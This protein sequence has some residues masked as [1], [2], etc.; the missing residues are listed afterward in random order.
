MLI[1]CWGARGSVPVSGR[2]Y[3]K[4]GG[5]T[6]CIEVRTGDGRVV[7]ID[8]G[9]GIRNLGKRLV[10]EGVRQVDLLLT[11][12][13]WDHLLGFPFFKPLYQP[14]MSIRVFGC[15]SAQSSVKNM[16]SDMMTPPHFPVP[17]KDA[18]AK[19]SF[20]AGC[21]D[22]FEIGPI[23]V[24]PTMLSHPNGG[25]GY[26]L[27]EN[28]RSLVF[29]TDNELRFQ[30]P[31]GGVFDDYVRFCAGADLLMHDAEFDADQYE[32][33]RTWGHSRFTDA[34]ELA[35]EADVKAL[36]L[37]HHNQDRTDG[38]IEDIAA[39]CRKAAIRQRPELECFAVYQGMEIRL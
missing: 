27:V 37:F 26:K 10:A 32:H 13:H 22:S 38:E 15:P 30:H 7:I 12:A 17:L 14:S 2:E 21:Q 31:G 34:V 1:R 24:T 28:G 18:K 9:S 20:H 29:L 8:A 11:H 3:L 33:T 39:A 4:Y 16:V 36:G 19:V 6:T 23:T 5:D 35:L 25:L